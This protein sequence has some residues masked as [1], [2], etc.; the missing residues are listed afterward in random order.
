MNFEVSFLV[1]LEITSGLHSIADS[2]GSNVGLLCSNQ[3]S[4]ESNTI[5][6]PA[7]VGLSKSSPYLDR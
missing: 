2:E 7:R 6:T 1:A 3:N 4:V 5:T